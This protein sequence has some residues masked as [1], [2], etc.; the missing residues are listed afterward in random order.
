M[1]RKIAAVVGALVADAAGEWF[2]WGCL[3]EGVGYVLY[4]QVIFMLCYLMIFFKLFFP[5][6]LSGKPSE[7][8]TVLIQIS[9]C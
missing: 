5:K 1:E 6:T 7:C 2:V 4:I 8:Q 3:G 9:W